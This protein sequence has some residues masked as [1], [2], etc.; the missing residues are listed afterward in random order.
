MSRELIVDFMGVSNGS[1]EFVAGSRDH[2]ELV[3]FMCPMVL[4]HHM[5]FDVPVASPTRRAMLAS[6][7][8]AYGQGYIRNRQ[9]VPQGCLFHVAPGNATMEAFARTLGGEPEAG[10]TYRIDYTVGHQ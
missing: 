2:I 9:L 5:S 7:L 6:A 3:G 8:S 4:V 1:L 10:Q